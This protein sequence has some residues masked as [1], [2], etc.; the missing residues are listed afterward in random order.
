M[1]T[2]LRAE[3]DA[4]SPHQFSA[5]KD[6]TTNIVLD[7]RTCSAP[8]RYLHSSADFSVARV[9][10]MQIRCFAKH[11]LIRA[12][13]TNPLR[14]EIISSSSV[15]DLTHDVWKTEFSFVGCW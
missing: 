10:Q 11:L 1:L 5:P 14:Y 3:F 6:G 15:L 2:S 9:P 12:V 13:L 4:T 7:K 8:A